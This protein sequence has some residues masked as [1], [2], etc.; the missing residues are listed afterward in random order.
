MRHVKDLGP[1]KFRT[2]AKNNKEQVCYYNFNKKDRAF[3]NFLAVRKQTWTD[4]LIF[5][6]VNLID[7]SNK[8]KDTYFKIGDELREFNDVAIQL[9]PGIKNLVRA[10]LTEEQQLINNNNNN[11]NMTHKEESAKSPNFFQDNNAIKKNTKPYTT[12]RIK[13]G[14]FLSNISYAWTNKEDFCNRNFVFDI[15]VL[16]TKNLNPF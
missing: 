9:K 13:L 6:I 8:Y 7:K 5:F 10:T 12:T 2:G 16:M 14:N 15:Y 11:N 3:H 4:A 1:S